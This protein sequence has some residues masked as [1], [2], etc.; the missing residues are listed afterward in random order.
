MKNNECLIP[1]NV[2]EDIVN[3][4]WLAIEYAYETGGHKVPKNM[5]DADVYSFIEEFWDQFKSQGYSLSSDKIA[6]DAIK[7]FRKIVKQKLEA[8][9]NDKR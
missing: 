3:K 7:K 1:E 4:N 8:M 9:E 2:I 5:Y 6:K